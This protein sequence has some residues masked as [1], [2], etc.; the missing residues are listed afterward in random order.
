MGAGGAAA[1]AG[2]GAGPAGWAVMIASLL[3]QAQA[4]KDAEAR[5]VQQL[6]RNAETES[7]LVDKSIQVTNRA[8]EKY[9]PAARKQAQGL[10]Q[11]AAE[12]SLGEGLQKATGSADLNTPY[13]GKV[14]DAYVAKQGTEAAANLDRAARLTKLMARIRAPGDLRLSEGYANADASSML[15]ANAGDMASASRAGAND[16]AN[17]HPDQTQMLI[18]QMGTTVGGNIVANQVYKNRLQQSGMFG[19]PLPYGGT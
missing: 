18:G 3:M 13:E 11:A 12:A 16:M 4:S 15:G 6:A 5:Q 17:I 14:S 10:A 9:D 7:G 8:A 1:G 19:T 2:A